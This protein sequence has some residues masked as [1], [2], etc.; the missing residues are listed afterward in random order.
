MLTLHKV[1]R[2]CA[3]VGLIASLSTAFADLPRG[4]ANFSSTHGACDATGNTVVRLAN[5]T[6]TSTGSAGGTVAASIWSWDSDV[7]NSKQSVNS[8]TCTFDGKTQTCAQ[9]TPYG[10][11]GLPSGQYMN[12]SGTYTYNTS[13]G[14]L[15]IAWASP[16][17][18]VTESWTVSTVDSYAARMDFVTSNYGL[19]HGRGWGSNASWSTYKTMAQISSS[20]RFNFAGARTRVVYGTGGYTLDNWI[21][22]SL[23]LSTYTTPSAPTPV[24]CMHYWQPTSSACGTGSNPRTGIIYH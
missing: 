5:Y 22:E 17:S 12:R 19:T 3:L 4:K 11:L 6:F 8:H 9:Y 2:T 16:W 24:N 15:A 10:W 7:E 13:T 23:N 1:A 21:S 20:Y 18:G 14:A